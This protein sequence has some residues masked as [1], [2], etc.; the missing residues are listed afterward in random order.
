VIALADLKLYIGAVEDGDDADDILTDLE[1][2]AV[3]LVERATGR[4]WGAS[5]AHTYTLEGTADYSIYVPEDLTAVTSV[6]VRDAATEEW[7]ALATDDWERYG[8]E[9][10]RADGEMWPSGRATV[11]IVATRGYGT[12]AEPGEVRQLVL[13][14]VN[15]QYRAGRKLALDDV[16]SPDIGRVKGWDRIINFYRGPLYG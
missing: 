5:E 9:F 12:G 7:T 4:F 14:L 2:R 6:S 3:A 16:G 11:K 1:V 8:R 10:L 13:D 15:W